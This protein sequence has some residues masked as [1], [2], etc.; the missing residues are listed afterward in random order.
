[1]NN[2]YAKIEFYGMK[3]CSSY[4]IHKTRPPKISKFDIR[5]QVTQWAKIAHL[6]ASIV[7]RD[8]IIYDAQ[9][10]VTLTLKQ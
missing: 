5:K 8:T 4:R 9:R 6:G 3:T 1:M 2:H 7:F 10:Q